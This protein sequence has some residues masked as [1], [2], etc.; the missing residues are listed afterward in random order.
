LKRSPSD[1]FDGRVFRAGFHCSGRRL[2][3]VHQEAKAR[4]FA[5]SGSVEMDG[6]ALSCHR[7]YHF[8]AD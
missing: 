8:L 3:P 5:A 1:F 7:L 6:P 2:P 4:A